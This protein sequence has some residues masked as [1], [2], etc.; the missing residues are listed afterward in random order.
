MLNEFSIKKMQLG[1]IVGRSDTFAYNVIKS[2]RASE[3]AISIIAKKFKRNILLNE[4]DLDLSEEL[5]EEKAPEKN[6]EPTAETACPSENIN[7]PN[8][9]IAVLED[10]EK[11]NLDI[12][13][14]LKKFNKTS[15]SVNKSLGYIIGF[16]KTTSQKA[17]QLD[18]LDVISRRSTNIEGKID[19]LLKI[20]G[21]EQ[22]ESP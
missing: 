9:I 14:E 11:T 22:N 17:G 18:W 8:D 5:R 15:E 20:W 2:Q 4:S 1:K 13:E 6:E 16:Q 3:E 12:L 7:Q 19:K 10:L 21:E